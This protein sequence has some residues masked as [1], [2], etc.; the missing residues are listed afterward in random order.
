M[1]NSRKRIVFGGLVGILS[2]CTYGGANAFSS[3]KRALHHGKQVGQSSPI[4]VRQAPRSQSM[5]ENGNNNNSVSLIQRGG[6]ALSDA[7]V[8]INNKSFITKFL[9]FA[10]ASILI[11]RRELIS[12]FLFQALDAYRAALESHPLQ[13]KVLTGASLAVIGDSL[14]QLRESRKAQKEYDVPRAAS[15]AAF[16]ACYRMFQHWVFPLIVSA[17]QGQVLYALFS[18]FSKDSLAF[19]TAMERTILYQFGV[20]PFFYYPIFF[21]FT[22]FVQGLSLKETFDRARQGF[23]PCWA[24]NLLFWI[25]T[26]MVMFGLVAEKWQIPFV[27]VMGILWSMILSA[28][29]GKAN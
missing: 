25:P 21:T 12:P 14:A 27:C 23:L 18:K 24:R 29:A 2:A 10:A 8:N 1:V 22:G 13:S 16:D 7:I 6:G 26:Q 28:F 17:G 4:I 11:S 15:F 19:A 9:G 20:V 3:P 5:A